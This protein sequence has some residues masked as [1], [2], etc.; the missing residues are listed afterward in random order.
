MLW[1]KEPWPAPA[2]EASDVVMGLA[3]RANPSQIARIEMIV[4]YHPRF[5]WPDRLL[6]NRAPAFHIA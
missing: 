2:P 5:G 6:T 3:A 4:A 1:A